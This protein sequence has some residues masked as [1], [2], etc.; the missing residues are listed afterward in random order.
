MT[1]V[2]SECAKGHKDCYRFILHERVSLCVSPIESG[3]IH[4]L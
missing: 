3:S 1:K 2:I 4:G